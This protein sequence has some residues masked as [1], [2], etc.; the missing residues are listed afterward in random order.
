[1]SAFTWDRCF[2]TGLTDV[3]VNTVACVNDES[4]IIYFFDLRDCFIKSRV[5]FAWTGDFEDLARVGN[6]CYALRR[7]GTLFE[8]TVGQGDTPVVNIIKSNVPAADSEGLAYDQ[9]TCR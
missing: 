4:G 7:D 5:R 1:M 9:K 6:D 2:V 3:D 8:V